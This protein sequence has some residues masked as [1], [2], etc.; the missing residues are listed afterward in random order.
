MKHLIA[1]AYYEKSGIDTSVQGQKCTR[2]RVYEE[3]SVRGHECMSARSTLF[4]HLM[5]QC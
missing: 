3:M 2:T 5:S 4:V 1:A